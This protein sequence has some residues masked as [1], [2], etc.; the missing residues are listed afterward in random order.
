MPFQSGKIV[1]LSMIPQFNLGV[2]TSAGD[3]V[4]LSWKKPKTIYRS[5]M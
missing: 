1:F 3:E 5:C 2:I 4:L